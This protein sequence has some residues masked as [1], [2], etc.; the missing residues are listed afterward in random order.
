MIAIL[1]LL[2]DAGRKKFHRQVRPVK[3]SPRCI[4]VRAE[5]YFL[6]E[7]RG[8][9]KHFDALQNIRQIYCY[10]IRYLICE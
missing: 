1:R 7:N 2:R 5:V 6:E 8:D 4:T 10:D 9:R 3:K